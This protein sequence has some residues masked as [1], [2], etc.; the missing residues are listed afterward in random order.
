[1]PVLA[2]RGWRGGPDRHDDAHRRRHPG[3]R[4]LADGVRREADVRQRP[5]GGH[6]PHHGRRP[7]RASRSTPARCS[8]CRTPPTVPFPNLAGGSSDLFAPGDR[9]LDLLST[10]AAAQVRCGAA[11]GNPPS[12]VAAPGDTVYCDAVT[13]EGLT[14]ISGVTWS[15]GRRHRAGRRRHA[16]QGDRR[17]PEPAS[18]GSTAPTASRTSRCRSPPRGSASSPARCRTP[19]RRSSRGSASS[20]SPRR[21]PRSAVAGSTSPSTSPSRP[22]A[23][24]LEIGNPGTLGAL[25]GLTGL[26]RARRARP[27]PRPPP[28]PGSSFDVGFGIQT[29]AM[30]DGVAR[31]T[32]LL[33]KDASL[34]KVQRPLGHQSPRAS[35]ASGRG[36]ASSASRPTSRRSPSAASRPPDP[37][38]SSTRKGGSTAPLPVSGLLTSQ[39]ALGPGEARPRL[40]PHRPPSASPRREEPLPG[41]AYAAGGSAGQATGT[42]TVTW[43]PAGLPTVSSD[44]GYQKLRVFDPVPARFLVRDRGRDRRLRARS[45]WRCRPATTLYDA[46]QRADPDRR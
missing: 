2:R 22:A 10:A 31:Q 29:G 38:S 5:H 12:G 28:R 18:S 30:A 4:G 6:R 34:L 26:V 39:G 24:D 36:S 11:P 21:P 3:R 37:P 19:C 46:A 14:G 9:L 45:T 17:G 20:A 27:P 33:P 8:R 40:Q 44:A 42:A 41:G 23:A 1:M 25:V 13:P 7:D 32:W 15:V 35:P 16:G 43:G